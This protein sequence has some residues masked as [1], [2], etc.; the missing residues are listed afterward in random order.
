MESHQVPKSERIVLEAIR[1]QLLPGEELLERVRFSDSRHNDVEADALIF[2]PNLGVAVIEIKGG[3]VAYADSQWTLSDEN[4]NSRRI[5]P[6]E[7]GRK[8]KHALRRYLERQ[9]EWNTGLIRSEW[10]V[11]MPFTEVN[12]DMGPEGRRELLIGKSDTSNIL[13][14]IR[15]V[16]S[17]PL[18]SDPFPTAKDLQL[19]ISL[20]KRPAQGQSIVG[21]RALENHKVRGLFLGILLAAINAGIFVSGFNAEIEIA[22]ALMGIVTTFGLGA[23]AMQAGLIGNKHL[24]FYLIVGLA[25]SLV[26]LGFGYY[27]HDRAHN[28]GACNSN[29]S[30]CVPEKSDIDCADLNMQVEVIGADVYSL[31]RDRDG[32][33]CE[34]SGKPN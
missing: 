18:N 6:V 15:K 10:F 20:L 26:G 9:S 30:G 8:A 27:A 4:G 24:K 14:Q 7:Q 16:L 1:Q 21:I 29:Y 19:A 13:E 5:N 28:Q 3:I 31:D 25:S 12:G 34:W 23:I 32:H 33:A 2:I 17:S 22:A 11:A